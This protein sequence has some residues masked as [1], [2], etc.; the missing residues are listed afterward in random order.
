MSKPGKPR[1]CFLMA[2]LD[3]PIT[4]SSARAI[5]VAKFRDAGRQVSY[6]FNLTWDPAKAA[7]NRVKHGVS[8]A[9]AATL[10][11]DPKAIS[12]YDHEHSFENEDRWI[13]LGRA[14]NGTLLVV[15]HTFEE[16][17]DNAAN[18]RLISAREAT[19][20]ERRHYENGE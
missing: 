4:A 17:G 15:V 10:L 14:D 3:Q 5:R 16:I 9:R 20:R 7:A 18:V 8:F 12:V 1:H 11:Q 19:R 6:K 2:R 13:T